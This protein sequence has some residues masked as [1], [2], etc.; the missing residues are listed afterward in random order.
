MNA[1]DVVTQMKL[2]HTLIL[3][4]FKP[5][6]EASGKFYAKIQPPALGLLLIFEI[7]TRLKRDE[8]R[9][10]LLY[11]NNE[12]TNIIRQPIETGTLISVGA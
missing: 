3:L 5:R 12:Y 11:I 4:A 8:R 1:G 10:N 9:R 2:D 7:A 6:A